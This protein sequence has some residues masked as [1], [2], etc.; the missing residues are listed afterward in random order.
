MPCSGLELTTVTNATVIGSVV[1]AVLVVM[2]YFGYLDND[3]ERG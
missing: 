2:R 3:I 1:L